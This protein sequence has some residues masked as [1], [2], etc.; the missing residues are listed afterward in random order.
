MPARL[1]GDEFVIYTDET[2]LPGT[3]QQFIEELRT[4]LQQE[5]AIFEQ[6]QL[7]ISPSIGYCSKAH[8]PTFDVALQEAD[9][10]MYEDK[11]N[12]KR[13]NAMNN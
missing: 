8:C 11:S 1:G 10:R 13:L 5:V 9:Q 12:I 3:A 4:A 7:R 6:Q 2:A